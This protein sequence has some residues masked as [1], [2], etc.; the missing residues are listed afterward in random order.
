MAKI[1]P[2]ETVV[3]LQSK[4]TEASYTASIV[5]V[6]GNYGG[7]SN[8][9]FITLKGFKAAGLTTRVKEEPESEGQSEHDKKAKEHAGVIVD[10]LKQAETTRLNAAVR[11]EQLEQEI[12]GQERA[13]RVALRF[14]IHGAIQAGMDMEHVMDH[15]SEPYENYTKDFTEQILAEIDLDTFVD[16]S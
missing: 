14:A 16:V 11:R 7:C 3:T 15:M 2:P 4:D 6:S 5:S 9:M 13:N 1:Y 12:A 8:D 10:V